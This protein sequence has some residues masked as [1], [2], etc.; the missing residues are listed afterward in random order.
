MKEYARFAAATAVMAAALGLVGLGTADEARAQPG[1]LPQWCP[2]DVW[3]PGWGPNSDWN[4]CHDDP[5]QVVPP[6]RPLHG[7]GGQEGQGYHP[8]GPDHPGAPVGPGGPGH[9]GGPGGQGGAPGAGGP[10]GP[11]DQA[12]LGRPAE[13]DPAAVASAAVAAAAAADSSLLAAGAPSSAG[14]HGDLGSAPEQAVTVMP[15]S[16]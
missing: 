8:G 15:S 3:D 13:A 11:A 9:P 4:R 16:K 2:G 7:R 5:V 6:P 10:G 14:R 1:P 12:E